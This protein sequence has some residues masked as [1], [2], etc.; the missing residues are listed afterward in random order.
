MLFPKKQLHRTKLTLDSFANKFVKLV[1]ITYRYGEK[2]KVNCE[3]GRGVLR[4]PFWERR[5]LWLLGEIQGIEFE[6]WQAGSEG[7]N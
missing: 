1:D 4:K 2:E 7:C 6:L 5:H 3:S